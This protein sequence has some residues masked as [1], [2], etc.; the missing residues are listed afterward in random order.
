MSKYGKILLFICLL[1]LI[2]TVMLI[3]LFGFGEL[4]PLMNYFLINHGIIG[5]SIAKLFFTII[6]IGFLEYMRTKHQQLVDKYYIIGIFAY[7]IIYLFVLGGVL[8]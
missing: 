7:I 6:P 3:G 2:S 1:D 4:N 8:L 5:M